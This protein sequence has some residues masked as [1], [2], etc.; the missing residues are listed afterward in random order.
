MV[1]PF[2]NGTASGALPFVSFCERTIAKPAVP[3]LCANCVV[4]GNGG[5]VM[6]CDWLWS[7]LKGLKLFHRNPPAS[8]TWRSAF[9]YLCWHLISKPLRML[10]C[11]QKPVELCAHLETLAERHRMLSKP[12]VLPGNSFRCCFR[13][14]QR[15]FS[16][17]R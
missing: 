10:R 13:S 2:F 7:C 11:Q 1:F 6:Q 8:N 3:S 17:C 4:N 14:V 15:M 12:S 5:L 9:S 16:S